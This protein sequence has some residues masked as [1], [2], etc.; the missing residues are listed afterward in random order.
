MKPRALERLPATLLLLLL[1]AF[2]PGCNAGPPASP[3]GDEVNLFGTSVPSGDQLIPVTGFGLE[4]AGCDPRGTF[5]NFRLS[6]A[7]AKDNAAKLAVEFDGRAAQCQHPMGD[8]WILSCSIPPLAIFPVLVVVKMDEAVVAQFSYDGASCPVPVYQQAG[9]TLAAPMIATNSAT[10]AALAPM[11]SRGGSAPTRWVLWP[12]FTPLPTWPGQP[13]STAQ[14]STS[15]DPP[16]AQPSPTEP[17]PTQ[18][19]PTQPQPTQAQPTQ[20]QPTEPPP[21]APPPTS[22]PRPSPTHKATPTEKPAPTQKPPPTQRPTPTP[23]PPD[24]TEPPPQ[25]TD[26]PTEPPTQPAAASMPVFNAAGLGL[27]GALPRLTLAA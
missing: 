16:P 21:T 1:A 12:T 13:T 23:K 26:P 6:D 25:P 19:Q 14:A 7:L 15:T 24:P 18:P 4:V 2:L 27:A 11:S 5:L 22:G 8:A 9:Q 10:A 20:P 17:P 3:A